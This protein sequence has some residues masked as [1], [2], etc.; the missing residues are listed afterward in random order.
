MAVRTKT[1]GAVDARA[2]ARER[3]AAFREREAKLESFAVDYFTSADK[4]D[5]IEVDLEES[6]V[7]LRKRAA[8]R[9]ASA[10]DEVNAAI[11]GMAALSVPAV[12]IAERLDLP[13]NAVRAALRSAADTGESVG[14]EAEQPEADDAS[15]ES[16]EEFAA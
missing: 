10:R 1:A 7:K 4:I 14:D 3:A 12:E 13:V 16:H 2:K 5:A 6:I 15:D 11:A 9:A 8:E